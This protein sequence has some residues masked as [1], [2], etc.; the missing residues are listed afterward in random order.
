M[1]RIVTRMLFPLLLLTAIQVSAQTPRE[2]ETGQRL[3]DAAMQGLNGPNGNLSDYLGSPLIINVW[4]SWCGP[5]RA[6]MSSLERLA[7]LEGASQFSIIGISTDDY[8]DRA[9][10]FLKSSNATIS[11]F[12]D[13]DLHLEKLLGA[14][15]LPLTVLVDSEGRVLKK[16]YGARRWDALPSLKL[17]CSTFQVREKF[18]CLSTSTAIPHVP[19]AGNSR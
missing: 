10:A 13:R 6:E 12:I 7:W 4:A 9:G 17:I 1:I 8:Q 2:I 19:K 15:R 5:C 14:D 3:P 11:H 18:K 16:I